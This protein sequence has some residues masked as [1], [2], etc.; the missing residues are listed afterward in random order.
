MYD[1]GFKGS[2]K[3]VPTYVY[4]PHSI[5]KRTLG[6]I[7][8]ITTT[9]RL[10]RPIPLN[11]VPLELLQDSNLS[12]KAIGPHWASSFP[13]YLSPDWDKDKQR[14]VVW[15][16]LWE[17]RTLASRK[18]SKQT[19]QYHTLCQEYQKTQV[20]SSHDPLYRDKIRL[21]IV[22]TSVSTVVSSITST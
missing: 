10:L 3:A 1:I 9:F 16:R 21:L 2:F 5:R 19:E 18:P 22:H 14:Q 6:L 7:S 17:L 12:S 8:C 15:R 13:N 4:K 11:W 20:K